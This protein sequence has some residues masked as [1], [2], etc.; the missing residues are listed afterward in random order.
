[1]PRAGARRA[2]AAATPIAAK[3]IVPR[4]L[5]DI[6]AEARCRESRCGRNAASG[7][8]V[9]DSG[10]ADRCCKSH[11]SRKTSSAI[12]DGGNGRSLLNGL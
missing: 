8:A 6:G 9:A 2:A 4:I 7:A 1:M 5:F 10:K 12:L 3:K 11:P